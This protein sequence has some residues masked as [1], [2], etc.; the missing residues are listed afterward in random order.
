MVLVVVRGVP[1]RRWVFLKTHGCTAH[2]N[3]SRMRLYTA[4][5]VSRRK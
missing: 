3:P 1:N 2:I 5:V 4:Y